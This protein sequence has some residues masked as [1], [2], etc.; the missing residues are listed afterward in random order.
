MFLDLYMPSNVEI[1]LTY[2]MVCEDLFL[3]E[4]IVMRLLRYIVCAVDGLCNLF[5]SNNVG[6]FASLRSS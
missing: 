2:V 5:G 3:C 1:S 4:L 6:V